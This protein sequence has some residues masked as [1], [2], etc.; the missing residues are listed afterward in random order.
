MLDAIACRYL[1]NIER[2]HIFEASNVVAVLVGIGATLMM[3]IDSAVGA[4]V[5]LRG[6]RVELIQP[7]NLVALQDSQSR[8]GHR[9]YDRPFSS[10]YRAIAAVRIDDAV[11]QV[12]FNDYSSAVTA[13]PVL[14]TNG[15]GANVLNH[16]TA[17][18]PT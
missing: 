6:H 15:G 5:M 7:K 17:C 11:W 4:E 13:S 14:L 2:V 18:T 12:K 3:R 9:S 8:Q 10:T 1:G 16:G